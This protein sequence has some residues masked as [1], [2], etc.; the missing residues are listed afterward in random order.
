MA[1]FDGLIGYGRGEKMA[2]KKVPKE[3]EHR[4]TVSEYLES[5][6]ADTPREKPQMAEECTVEDVARVNAKIKMAE[7]RALRQE[8]CLWV[9]RWE[10][11]PGQ[12]WKQT[13]AAGKHLDL[14]VKL[15]EIEVGDIKCP[16]RVI[17]T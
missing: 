2:E 3:G 15:Q 6:R 8:V 10:G 12:V 1:W 11:S 16:G 14:A 7:L 17:Q 5:V 13:Q 4:E 9:G